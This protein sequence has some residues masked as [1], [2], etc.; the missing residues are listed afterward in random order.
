MTNT[1]ILITG[2]TGKT[3]RRVADRL[4]ARD[5]PTRVG[6]RSGNPPFDWH[7]PATWNAALEGM[8]AAY[9]TYVP[10]LAMPGATDA[11]TQFVEQARSA[12]LNRLVL[13]SGRGEPE[14]ERCEQIVLDS[15]LEATIV[16]AAVFA[17]NFSESFLVDAVRSG[18][19]PFIAG[20][21]KEPFI[22]ADDIA[23]VVAAT[24]TETGHNGKV[25]EVT[26]P[27]LLDFHEAVAE[28]SAASGRT[29][30][31][32]PITP[33]EY[34]AGLVQEAGLPADEAAMLRGLF[35]MIFDGRNAQITDGVERALGRQPR[36]FVDYA[37]TAAATGVWTD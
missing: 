14:A 31:Y 35:E 26:G 33:D 27:R 7:D 5:V 9:L 34:E 16:R 25:Y 24:L 29:V 13:L 30:E 28:I 17:Q 8:G 6:S 12:G 4:A 37:R 23:D 1:P 15:G 22:D 10:D 2:G 11:I 19:V 20:D 36:D 32:V 21:V 18:V 3:G